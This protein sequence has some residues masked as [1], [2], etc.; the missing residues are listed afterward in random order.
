MARSTPRASRPPTCSVPSPPPT[1]SLTWPPTPP[2]PPARPSMC[3]SGNSP[4]L[5]PRQRRLNRLRHFR[6]IRRH[7]RF[8]ALDDL[9]IFADQEFAE[10]PFDISRI[11]RLFARE[12][13]V[14][15]MPI[16]PVHFDLIKQ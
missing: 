15:W 2:W 13:R 12:F 4:R 11:R 1:V 14:K 3:C 7:L 6:R 8:E 10:V 9:P 5:F 16:R